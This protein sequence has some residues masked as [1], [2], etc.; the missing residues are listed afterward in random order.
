MVIIIFGLPGSGKTY[1]AQHLSEK[2]SGDYLSSDHLRNSSFQH[3]DYSEKGKR[4]IYEKLLEAVQKSLPANPNKPIIV[5]ATFYLKELRDLFVNGIKAWHQQIH[6]IEIT[7]DERLI[8]KRTATKR[9]NSDAGFLISQ[10][11]GKWFEPMK[12]KHLV[13]ESKENN[14]EEMLSKALLFIAGS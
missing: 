3:K 13:L 2:I 4:E 10:L 1:F 11:I 7:A 5:D 8:E 9:E 12:E 6:F 14:I